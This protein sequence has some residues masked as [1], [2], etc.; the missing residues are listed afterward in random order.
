MDLQLYDHLASQN[1][2]VAIEKLGGMFAKSGLL[3]VQTEA[4]GAVLA[5]TCIAERISPLEFARTYHIIE[6]KPS[7]R[8]D[9]MQSR[10]CQAGGRVKWIRYDDTE[11]RAVFSYDGNDCEMSFSIE[12]AKRAGLVRPNSG[13]TKHPDAML[14]ARLVSKAVRMLC[15]SVN[16]GVY[17]PEEVQDFERPVA[18]TVVNDTTYIGVVDPEPVA[19]SEET[20]AA[21]IAKMQTLGEEQLAAATMIF[22]ELKWIDESQSCAEIS[23]AHKRRTV[24][25]WAKFLAKVDRRAKELG[26]V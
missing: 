3:G 26:N 25:G 14:R 11:A 16:A 15:P 24:D 21:F 1:A 23:D 5:M 20:M 12:D 13:W 8:A 19:S 10:F 17:T 22:R 4:Q 9:A 18:A 2:M 6:G 7:M